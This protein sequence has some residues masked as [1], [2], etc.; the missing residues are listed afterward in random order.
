MTSASSGNRRLAIGLLCGLLLQSP[1]SSAAD[2]LGRL[3][4]T[5]ERRA[6]LDRQRELNLPQEQQLGE[7]DAWA[8]DGIVLRTSGKRTVWINGTPINEGSPLL[9]VKAKRSHP[10]QAKILSG[11]D[12][13]ALLVGSSVQPATGAVINPLGNGSIRVRER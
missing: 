11:Q 8:L 1:L 12:E 13:T 4:F 5:P 9:G 3:F 10:G 6:A 7:N 2:E